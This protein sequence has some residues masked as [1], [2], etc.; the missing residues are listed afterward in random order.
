VTAKLCCCEF[1]RGGSQPAR[2]EPVA[3]LAPTAM[4]IKERSATAFEPENKQEIAMEK[5][6][7]LTLKSNQ[8]D[9]PAGR[10]SIA[11][12]S[13]SPAAV[14][15]LIEGLAL[16]PGADVDKLERIMSM[17]E[18]LK[19]KEAEFAYNA[20]KGRILKKLAEIKIVKNRSA[21]NEIGNAKPQTGTS[22][23][24]KYAPLEEIDKHLGPL[25]A[26]E[27]MD[28]SYS[29]EP[30]QGGIRIRGRLKHLPSGYYEDSFMSAPPDTTGGKTNV[31]AVGSTN[32]YLRR[33]VAC[34]IFNIVVIGDDD[35][36]NGG[37][38]AEIQTKRILALIK[39]AKVGPK[40]LKHHEGA[41]RRGCRLSQ[42]CRRDDC[43]ARLSQGDQHSREVENWR[44]STRCQGG[45]PARIVLGRARFDGD[46]AL[47]K[48]MNE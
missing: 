22:G 16:D 13:D 28:L 38:I 21:L 30:A 5:Q 45:R 27:D 11:P 39:K 40:F 47:P 35:D 25:L 48:E 1:K 26:E 44:N 34:N 24:F 17:Y 46:D 6:A 31:Q 43:S 36:G 23:A 18:A 10:L 41:E 12:P 15:M 29:D 7:S 33:Y 42:G 19:A 37:T 8:S 9:R 20:A 3:A 2:E 4:R 32:S 14:L